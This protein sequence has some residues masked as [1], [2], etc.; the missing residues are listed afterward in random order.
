ML[1][2]CVPGQ[3]ATVWRDGVTLPAYPAGNISPVCTEIARLRLVVVR[4][5]IVVRLLL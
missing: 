5:L 3:T 4:A 2:G 1:G